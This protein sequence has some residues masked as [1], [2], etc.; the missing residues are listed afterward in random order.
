MSNQFQ[1]VFE[2]LRDILKKHAKDF[3]VG[4]DTADH[5]GLEAPVGSATLQAWGGKMKSP[6]IPVGWVQVG[7]AYVSFHLMGVYGN[8]KLLEDCSGDLRTHMQGK[9]CFN[10]KIV[11]EPLFDELERLTIRSLTGMKK[12]GYVSDK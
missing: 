8:P 1:S 7:K 3:V 2:R 9:S 10:F 4:K 12:A 5:Y 6:M 11:D